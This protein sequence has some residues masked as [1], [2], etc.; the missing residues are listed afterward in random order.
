VLE[1]RTR[2]VCVRCT[3]CPYCNIE[4]AFLLDSSEK[5]IFNAWTR[6]L[7]YTNSVIAGYNINPNC[8]RVA[9]ISYSD[10]AVVSI[11]LNRY[12]DRNSLQQAV[13]QLPVLNG[14]SILANAFNVLRTRVFVRGVIREGA[15]LIA[16]VVTDQIQTS[17]QL[18]NEA[19]TVKGQGIRVIGVGINRQGL[20]NSNA[21]YGVTTNNYAVIVSDYNQLPSTVNR[22]TAPG[23]WGCF[24]VTTTTSTTTPRPVG[25]CSFMCILICHRIFCCAFF[26]Y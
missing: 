26:A 8:V 17:E 15:V 4:L 13:L 14:R 22:I 5:S 20:M 16:V 1:E 7:V 9:V 25:T 3:V 12:G 23:S 21:L 24:E 18:T 2:N 10:N 6:M 19:N 11:E